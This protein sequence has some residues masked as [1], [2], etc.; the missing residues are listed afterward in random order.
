MSAATAAAAAIRLSLSLQLGLGPNLREWPQ[1][2]GL[3][4]SLTLPFVLLRFREQPATAVVAAAVL[5]TV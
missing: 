4:V 5:C 2:T 3:Y 1:S